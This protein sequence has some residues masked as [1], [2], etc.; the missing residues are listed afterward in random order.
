MRLLIKLSVCTVVLVGVSGSVG[1][2]K[3][4]RGPSPA[5]TVAASQPTPTFTKDIAP[6]LYKNCVT[7]HRPGE[8]APMSLISYNDVRPWS[9]AIKDKV[10]KREMP[11]WGADPSVG[12]YE[13]DRSLSQK[14]I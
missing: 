1:M 9:K 7:C 5:K 10:A 2:A 6:I 12:K 8:V 4:Q 3:S 13:N 11:P 14:D